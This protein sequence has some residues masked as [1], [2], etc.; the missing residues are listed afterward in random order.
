MDNLFG[1]SALAN[2][3]SRTITAGTGDLLPTD[4]YLNYDVTSGNVIINLPQISAFVSGLGALGNTL[5]LNVFLSGLASVSS[6]N[7]A[8]IVCYA[9]DNINGETSVD[10]TATGNTNFNLQ[11]TP[12][13]WLLTKAG[14]AGGGTGDMLLDGTIS[15]VGNP[16]YPASTKG[17]VLIVTNTVNGRIGG[18]SGILVRKG[19]TIICTTTSVAGTQAAV[20]NNFTVLFGVNSARQNFGVYIKTAAYTSFITGTANPL[21]SLGIAPIGSYV[22]ILKIKHSQSFSGGAISQVIAQPHIDGIEYDEF[23]VSQAVGNNIGQLL[24]PQFQSNYITSSA[25]TVSID[26]SLDI[27]GGVDTDLTQGSVSIWF[28]IQ[29]ASSSVQSVI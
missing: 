26:L 20:G 12:S 28:T 15:C 16:N 14:S 4:K 25:A 23:T 29:D 8:T 19:D 2:Q 3:I 17:D 13:G 18:S 1:T 6:P 9:G 10:L 11:A 7:S 5:N 22:S 24:T 21:I 27:T